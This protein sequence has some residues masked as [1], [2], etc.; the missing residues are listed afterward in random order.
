[1]TSITPEQARAY[2]ERWKLVKQVQA[3]ELRSVDLRTRLRQL[4]VLMASRSLFADD[5]DRERQTREVRD[6]WMRIRETL[7]G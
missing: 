6:R 2:L 7:R 3:E 4:S 1:M 5:A